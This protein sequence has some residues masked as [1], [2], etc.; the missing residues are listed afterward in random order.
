MPFQIDPE[1]GENEIECGNCG[2]IIYAGL[3]RCPECGVNLYEPETDRDFERRVDR[4]PARP[5]LFSRLKGALHRLTG[6]PY[7]ADQIFGDSLDQAVL[8][9]DLLVRVG[10]DRA[11]VE[12][13][14]AFER[15]QAPHASRSSLLRSA[16]QRWERDN[17][18][19]GP[20]E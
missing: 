3:S 15:Q 5:G 13:L 2:A 6:K 1:P 17:R 7:T 16:I 11:I 20:G 14:I 10:G 4:I 8:Y 18:V 19:E 9:N 12:R